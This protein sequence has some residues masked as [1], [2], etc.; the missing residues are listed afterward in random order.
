[1]N[2]LLLNQYIDLYVD[3]FK[4]INKMEIYKWRAVK[5]FRKAWNPD[6]ENFPKMLENA[7]SKTG[8]LMASGNYF[9]RRIIIDLA[10]FDPDFIKNSFKRLYDEEQDLFYRIENFQDQ[11]EKL[12]S[13]Y[14]PDWKGFQDDRAV[15]VYLTLRFPNIYSFYKFKM[16]KDFCR[17][18]EHEYDPKPGKKENVTQFLHVCKLVKAELEKNGELIN[19]HFGRLGDEEYIDRSLNILTQ[20]FIYAVA[21]HLDAEDQRQNGDSTYLTLKNPDFKQ[22]KVDVQLEGKHVNFASIQ[23]KRT[24]VGKIG[25]EIVIKYEMKNLPKSLKDK[26]THASVE[27]GDG[28]GYDI[29]SYDENGKD[30]Y[31]EVKTTTGDWFKPFYATQHE[32]ERSIQE[33]DSFYLYRLF[34]LD[35]EEQKAD[36]FIIRGDL[37]EYC[38]DPTEYK[39]EFTPSDKTQVHSI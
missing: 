28:L 6:D 18:L 32:L 33:R 5:Q 19:K 16:F 11:I 25:E 29:L 2:R 14:K 1:M 37:T 35:E 17:K 24:H 20:D 8:N 38:T 3:D 36:F 39:I 22:E 27:E 4:R 7:L 9:P 26:V 12:L 10:N 34:N 30:K 31:I 21:N 23:K 13:S 15:M